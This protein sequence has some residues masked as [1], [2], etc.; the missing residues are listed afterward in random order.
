MIILCANNV[1]RDVKIAQNLLETCIITISMNSYRVLLK[2]ESYSLIFNT[3]IA[4]KFSKAAA[5]PSPA[6]VSSFPLCIWMMIA[7]DLIVLE[8][9]QRQTSTS[10]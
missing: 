5:S 4:E 8:R 1:I 6:L 10:R 7:A 3:S 9:S 2:T